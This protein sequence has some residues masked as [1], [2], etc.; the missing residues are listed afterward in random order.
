MVKYSR[1]GESLWVEW[2]GEGF[3]SAR[4]SSI[5]F[6]THGHIDLENEI[7]RRALASSLQRDGSVDS[8]GAAFRLAE[9]G[10]VTTG[11]CGFIDD[12][13]HLSLC[14]ERGETH[15]GN[16]VDNILEVTWVELSE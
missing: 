7:V 3:V 4:P 10:I 13:R 14:D 5:I 16:I 15:Y 2:S 1:A 12:E 6:F 9:S 8:L 11:Y